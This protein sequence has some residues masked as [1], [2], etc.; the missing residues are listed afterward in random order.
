[1]I[2]IDN[3]HGRQTSGKC[4]P[5][6]RLQEWKWTRQAAAMLAQ[7][8]KEN[9][10][11]A[12]LLVPGEDD[13]PLARR[14]TLANDIARQTPAASLFRSTPT[15]RAMALNGTTHRDG[16]YSSIP[17]LRRHLV[18]LQPR[19]SPKPPLPAS[20]ATAPLH[21]AA[22]GLPTLPFCATLSVPPSSPKTCSTTTPTMPA[23]SS[24][25]RAYA[26]SSKSTSAQ[27][28]LLP[29]APYRVRVGS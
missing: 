26:P 5:D 18:R 3:G 24:P 15:P 25:P 2:I 19:S 6:S 20:S 14:C 9:D 13:V 8:L 28:S 23:F 27:F 10:I 21:P 11:A 1:M 17:A 12:T 29:L 16:V 4:S 7:R 22:T